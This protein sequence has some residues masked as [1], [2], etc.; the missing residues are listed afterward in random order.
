[1]FIGH[2]A[3]GLASKRLSPTTSLGW[4]MLAPLLADAVW[5]LFLWLGLESVRI[6]PGDTAMTPL[7]LHDYPYSHSLLASLLWSAAAGGAFWLWKR[8]RRAALVIAAGVF[9]H[10]VLDFVTHR[11]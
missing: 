7:D 10:W 9:S 6:N 1:M 8:D 2:M 3:V 11:P 5:P 4:L